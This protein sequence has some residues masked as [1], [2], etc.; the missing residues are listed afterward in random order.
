MILPQKARIL[1][2]KE[3]CLM[4]KK[5]DV[6]NGTYRIEDQIG[7]GGGGTVYKAYHLRLE[8]YVV[9]KR[10]N[11]AW[12]GLMDSRKEADIIKNL[13]HQYLPQAYDF[14]RMEDGIY[15]VMDFVPG[16]SLDKYIKSGYRFTQQQVLYWAKQI[17]E[18][19]IYLHGL[20]PP[21]IHSDIKP[22][23]IM[24]DLEGNVCLIDFNVS[25]TS[26]PDSSI[27]ATS[28]GYAAP[29]QYLNIT[30]INQPEPGKAYHPRFQFDMDTALD[31]RS[32]IYSLG[33]TLYHLMTGQRP[34]K[35]PETQLPPI[36]ADLPDFDEAL[37]NIVNKMTHYDPRERYQTAQ[38]VYDDLCN[39]KRLD[40]RYRSHKRAKLV[41]NVVFPIIMVGAVVLGT[42]GFMQMRK[43]GDSAFD[44]KIA[45]ADTLISNKDYENA[46]RTYEEAI[47]M[48]PD[49]IEAYS[50][51]LMVYSSQYDYDKVIEYG[52]TALAQHNFEAAG[53]SDK[54]IAQF[55]YI[56]GDAYFAE[57][58]YDK[59]VEHYKKAVEFDQSNPEY[60]RDFAIALSRS[61][62]VDSAEEMLQKATA[63]GLENASIALAKAEIDFAKGN[64]TEA[65][66]GFKK[67]AQT[68]S[69][70]AL[71]QRAYLYLCR[72]YD[73]M[74]DHD[75]VIDT[76]S[77]NVSVFTNDNVRIANIICAEAYLKKAETANETQRRQYAQQSI[78]YYKRV[79]DAGGASEQTLF[80]LVTAYQYV[81][82]NQNAQAILNEL[83]KDYPNDPDVYARLAILE[84]DKQAKLSQTL[85]NYDNFK[86]Y[87]EKAEKL[88][89]HNRVSGT[90]STYIKT[91]E[92]LM[93]R[94]KKNNWIKE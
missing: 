86:K 24:I 16:A 68:S 47:G 90:S 94:L 80:N 59:A 92:Q 20:K 43:E 23:N 37:I 91:M 19:L 46:R 78:E 48:K 54:Q 45:Y 76:I 72:A 87:Y 58:N 66:E 27:S 22:A 52:T 28:R 77:K 15:T 57:E 64:Y 2:R 65:A 93:E 83:V 49:R 62:Y 35:L 74:G 40:K 9:V 12:V 17:T 1:S 50:G 79:K 29:E 11:D 69:D 21:I 41:V 82:D 53:N 81:D 8:K 4:I 60:Y 44:D 38:E 3:R 51:M 73:R 10:I 34:P 55:E 70:S 5:G 75:G 71:I 85:R 56:L 31:Q 14:L 7:A 63:M 13:K 36:P 30:P 32:D 25:M 6:I 39:I 67:A 33:A 26:T 18:A 42:A 88:D 61:A 84:A 89:Q